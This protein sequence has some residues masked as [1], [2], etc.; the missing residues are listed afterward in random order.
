MCPSPSKRTPAEITVVGAPR[1]PWSD[2]Y[3]EV[4]GAP[5]WLDLLGA[6]G[7][8]LLLNL[9]FAFGYR[10]VGGV[11]GARPDSLADHFFFSVQTMGTIGYGVLYPQT[12]AAQALVTSE[13]IVG[14]S[15]VALT[16]GI[17]FA[18]F[19]VPR[20]RMQFAESATISPVNGVPTLMF[21]LGNERASAII[22][23]TVRAVMLC[24]E[25]TAE[26]VTYYRMHD[27]ALL[28]ERSPAISRSW[29]V[30]HRIDASSLLA[31]ATPESLE[32][33]EVE[34]ILTVV[35]IDE[36]SAQNVSARHT[37]DH[38][39]VHWGAR[40]ADMLSERPDGGLTLDMKE[41]HRV[42]ATKR[43]ETFPYPR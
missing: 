14:V 40:H 26:G 27:L 28:R 3:H 12:E 16:T 29:T 42:V 32:R 17:L 11:A 36:T 13:V 38:S 7:L 8:F 6:A 22:E 5:W 43:T 34:F 37:Y 2:L 35:G 20:S 19:S 24:T 39:Q 33:D 25:R 31:G 41:F 21:R 18:K 10:A 4:L 23:A 15:L 1:T 9:V 30:M